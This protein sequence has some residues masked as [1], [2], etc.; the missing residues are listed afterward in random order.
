MVKL[1]KQKVNSGLMQRDY[2]TRTCNALTTKRY[3]CRGNERYYPVKTP[4]TSTTRNAYNYMHRPQ[5][6]IAD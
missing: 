1:S 2:V 4:F 3:S 6:K 5:D